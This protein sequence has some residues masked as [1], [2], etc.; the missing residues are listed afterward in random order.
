M[1]AV[2]AATTTSANS[3]GEASQA[4]HLAETPIQDDPAIRRGVLDN[5]LRY[6]V[7]H[8]GRPAGAVSLRLGI[9]VG[10][11]DEADAEQGYAHFIEHM[12]F[13]STRDFP[14]NSV[15]G[16]FAGKGVAFGRDINAGTGLRTTEFKLDLPSPNPA[17]LALGLRWL[18]NVADGVVFDPAS[19][20]TERGVVLAEKRDRENPQSLVER[21][22]QRFQAPSARSTLRE[23]IGVDA[24]LTAATAAALA[25]FHRRWYQPGNA[26][27]VIVGDLPLD[28]LEASVKAT[29]GSWRGETRPR[30]TP[31][32]SR[33]DTTRGLDT[34]VTAGH[35]LINQDSVC[36]IAASRFPRPDTLARVRDDALETIWREIL[37]QR[38]S[39]L[40]SIAANHLLGAAMEVSDNEAD[41][42]TI[43]LEIYPTAGGSISALR[44]AQGEV[45]RFEEAGPT[46]LEVLTATDRVRSHLRGAITER[47]AETIDEAASRLLNDASNDRA[48]PDPRRALSDF[49][50]AVEDLTVADVRAAFAHDWQGAGP[51]IAVSSPD[52]PSR[53]A[54]RDAW[55]AE[56]TGEPLTRYADS[57]D[58]AWP[59]DFGRPGAVAKREV[60]E[61]GQF[62]RLRFANGV[63]LNF[64]KTDFAKDNVEL[65]VRFGA[66]RLGIAGSD[67]LQTT[68]GASLL[69]LGGL[70]K[71]D[72]D[73]VGRDF[74]TGVQD[75]RLAVGENA[76]IFKASCASGGVDDFLSVF[77]AYMTDPGFRPAADPL[78]QEAINIVY[79]LVA[80]T[81]E[82]AIAN[83]VNAA[84]PSGSSNSLP[85]RALLA[86]LDSARID[87][88]L[89]PALT[90]EP[91]D[92]TLVGDLEE[93]RAI[94]LVAATFGALPPRTP[95]AVTYG[96]PDFIRFPA[97]FPHEIHAAYTGPA[98]KAGVELAWPLFVASPARRRDAEVVTVLAAIF[99]DALRRRVRID[100]GKT[101]SPSV[102]LAE[103]QDGDQGLLRAEIDSSPDDVPRMIAETSDIARRLG[104]GDITDEQLVAARA[105]MLAAHQRELVTNAAWAAALSGSA[106]DDEALKAMLGYVDMMGGIGLTDV[107]KAAADW[108]LAEP[109]VAIARAAEARGN[110][111]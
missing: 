27:V 92:I 46:D 22:I 83:A 85:P 37:D 63:V 99:D 14:R 62:V 42:R 68:L 48:S 104:R 57:K 79:R 21:E 110:R 109:I 35:G 12:A 26:T 56:Q 80:T 31:T 6:I 38:L 17:D 5:G 43:C 71:I 87:Q 61:T 16:A 89:R 34:F 73:G 78:I 74:Q 9:R 53:E 95:N 94:E 40:R 32:P 47:Y 2:L 20:D 25:D 106:H 49:D 65:V 50:I 59:Y 82:M 36:R 103:T 76:F 11:F 8:S 39:S 13:R 88:L 44:A 86:G 4:R 45:R 10:S 98:S 102:R 58:A 3:A 19:V 41:L 66:G 105:P 97:T 81:P 18:R 96:V 7:M 111:Q 107:R 29:F 75:F 101:Y 90:R 55:K 84:T 28:R 64:K 30:P 23:P 1:S 33:L 15:D 70:G 54:V 77:A 69:N 24:T 60:V 108:L 91:I 100:L 67:Y 51:L 72:Y 52:A 93:A